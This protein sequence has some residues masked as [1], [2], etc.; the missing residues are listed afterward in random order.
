MHT[1]TAKTL[2]T[3]TAS[4]ITFCSNEWRF[5]DQCIEQA[6]LFSSQILIPVCDHFFNGDQEDYALLEW[7]YNKHPTCTF[8]EFHFDP[9]Q[10]YGLFSPLN[11][12]D[13][14]ANHHWHNSGR[15][16]AFYFLEPEIKN[17]LFLDVDEIPDGTK[18]AQWLNHVQFEDCAAFR[19]CGHWYFRQAEFQSLEIP[20]TSLFIQKKVLTPELLLT[21]DERTGTFW[22]AEGNKKRQVKGLQDETL[23]H[24]Y[25]WV[26]T[27]EEML[28]KTASWSH[29]WERDW[30][31][32]IEEEYARE[33]TGVDFVRKYHYQTVTPFFDPLKLT[34]P[35]LSPIDYDTH[36]TN[37]SQFSNVRRVSAQDIFR[38]DLK[39]RFA[40]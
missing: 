36:L 30:K 7:F 32:L 3:E 1:E 2:S 8:L 34:K 15:L 18:F 5:L 24:H 38:L 29:H 11:E 6:R 20:D 37:L 4:V 23:F 13:C 21:I 16:V 40:L 22:K 39:H 10:P 9:N 12:D 25:S 27:K 19:F 31:T 35:N 17:V 14:D 26:R 28:K 33:F